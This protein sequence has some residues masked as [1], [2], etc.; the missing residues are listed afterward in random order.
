ME[1]FEIFKMLLIFV[2]NFSTCIEINYLI[3][4]H[5]Y[6]LILYIKYI[7]FLK[8]KYKYIQVICKYKIIINV[9]D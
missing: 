8:N 7:Y 2:I 6:K 4:T 9:N 3:Y 1:Q 5:L